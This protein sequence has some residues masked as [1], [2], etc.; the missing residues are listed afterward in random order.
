MQ[1]ECSSLTIVRSIWT[2][3]IYICV[4]LAV[5]DKA[6]T[7]WSWDLV[8]LHRWVADPSTNAL[9]C[10]NHFRKHAATLHL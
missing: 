7:G 8:N 4:A 9:R 1:K 2:I 6:V 10:T 5:M 3:Y